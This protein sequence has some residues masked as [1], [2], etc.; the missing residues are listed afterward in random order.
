MRKMRTCLPFLHLAPRSERRW[1][2]SC[3]PIWLVGI[4]LQVCGGV[5]GWLGRCSQHSR[6]CS[7]LKI[8]RR[9]NFLPIV[10]SFFCVIRELKKP[11][12]A[13]TKYIFTVLPLVTV[14][15]LLLNILTPREILSSG[16]YANKY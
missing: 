6:H 7:I 5:V 14:I 3:S 16:L 1:V 8:N 12:K 9:D 2:C 11:R 13:I 15:Y 10:I 4:C